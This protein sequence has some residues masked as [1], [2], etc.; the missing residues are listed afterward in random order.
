MS[1]YEIFQVVGQVVFCALI[2]LSI[3]ALCGGLGD[4]L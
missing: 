4:D 1:G 3:F 2:L